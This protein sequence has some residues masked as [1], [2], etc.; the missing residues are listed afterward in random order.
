MRHALDPT[1]VV[2]LRM[3]GRASHLERV[4][5]CLA[6]PTGLGT[7]EGLDAFR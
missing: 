4:S 5:R 3:L 1:F 7:P 6:R 2:S